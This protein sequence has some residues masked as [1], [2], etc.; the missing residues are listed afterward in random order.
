MS[1]VLLLH[2]FT[3]TRASWGPVVDALE[4]K[5]VDAPV[6]SL[7]DAADELATY[8]PAAWVGYSMGGRMALH[9]ALAHPDAVRALVLV[10]AT[11]GIDDERERAARRAS[12]E[13][14]ARRLDVEGVDAFLAE[15]LAQPMFRGVPPVA[16]C[17]DAATMTGHLRLAGTGTQ[18][19]LWDRLG[20]LTMPVLVVVGEEDKPDF[21][22]IAYHL[23]EQIPGAELAVVPEAGHLVGLDRPD[24]LNRL[25]LDFLQ[26]GV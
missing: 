11:A 5:A 17:D 19:P 22:A 24:E 14:L 4:A 21:K 23:A 7:W 2:G 25:L 16:R 26:D 18:E 12:D 1:R 9:L 10:S 3:Q 8:G 13:A 6:A 15:W 20:E